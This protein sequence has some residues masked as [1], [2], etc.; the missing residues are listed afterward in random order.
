MARRVV[1][2]AAVLLVAVAGCGSSTVGDASRPAPV[3]ACLPPSPSAGATA[4][5]VPSATVTPVSGA[6]PTRAATG[7]PLPDLTLDC[8]EGGGSV[9]VRQLRRP[10]I[11]NLWASWCGPCVKEMPAFQSYASRAGHRVLILGVDTGDPKESAAALLQD[12]KVTY[13]NLY[14]QE[15]RLLGAVGRSALPLTLFVDADG[16]IQHLYNSVAL[17]EPA[18]TRLA[19]TYLGVAV[20]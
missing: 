11:V 14:D 18:I 3:A 16:H 4:T 8:F 19:Q 9:H 2:L 7:Q 17:D 6:T 10:A 12:L 1:S 5:P 20:G 13:P 15:K